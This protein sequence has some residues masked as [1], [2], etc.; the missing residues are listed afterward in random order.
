MTNYTPPRRSWPRKFADAFRGLALGVLGQSSFIV[1][2]PCA[3]LV[4]AAGIWL[5]VDA[6]EWRLLV[7]CIATVLS[8]ELF[9][10]ALERLAKAIDARQNEHLAAALN[11]ASAAVLTI[12]LGAAIV[13][14]LIFVPRLVELFGNQN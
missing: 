6:N 2:L 3:V 14:G 1:H 12:A 13:G 9:N 11:I 10:S 7:L 8:A 4:I 5:H